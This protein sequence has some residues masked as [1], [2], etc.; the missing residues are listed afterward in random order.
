[1]ANNESFKETLGKTSIGDGV[2]SEQSW[3]ELW[4]EKKELGEGS[5][6]S[7]WLVQP[8]DKNAVAKELGIGVDELD[9]HGYALKKILWDHIT[10]MKNGL[11]HLE[12]ELEIF[13][14]L[15]R[16]NHP[17]IMRCYKIYEDDDRNIFFLTELLRGGDLVDVLEGEAKERKISLGEVYCERTVACMAFQLLH[18]VDAFHRNNIMHRDIK[19]DNICLSGD[20]FDIGDYDSNDGSTSDV[21][22]TSGA[23]SSTSGASNSTSNG[24]S[25]S[26][27]NTSNSINGASSSTSDT[28][29]NNTSFQCPKI[30][31]VDFGLGK[32]VKQNRFTKTGT[33]TIEYSSPEL[34]RARVVRTEYGHKVDVWS[35]GVTCWIL[36]TG[37]PPFWP[38]DKSKASQIEVINGIKNKPPPFGRDDFKKIGKQAKNFLA[39]CLKKEYEKRL[40][41]EDLLKQS[42][43]LK[44]W[45]ESIKLANDDV[46]TPTFS[47]DP[48]DIGKTLIAYRTESAKLNG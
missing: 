8:K 16:M 14:S 3:E 47:K 6:G 45:T 48:L 34:I 20:W 7:V 28:N 9:P 13:C 23:S 30:K 42:D 26:T 24:A 46:N 25:S 40:S 18:A 44:P 5:F 35:V 38:R 41:P 32:I 4:N 39:Y 29:N 43:W 2:F 31:I 10:K 27:S 17:N 12:K 22:S 21:S 33:G 15:S 19:L 36:L 1:M 11:H 37:N